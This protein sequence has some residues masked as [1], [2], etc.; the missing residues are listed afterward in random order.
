LDQPN[1][2]TPYSL[3]WNAFDDYYPGT[4]AAVDAHGR[5]TVV[6][7]DDAVEKDVH[8][9]LIRPAR[10]TFFALDGGTDGAAAPGA[11]PARLAYEA[12][13]YEAWTEYAG[14]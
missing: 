8:P 5:Y 14:L 12:P 2:L 10:A 11:R 7:D 1:R 13:A 4:V 3:Q 6:Y 9:S